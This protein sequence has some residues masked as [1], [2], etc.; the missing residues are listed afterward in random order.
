MARTVLV[1]DDSVTMQRIL[2]MTLSAL[3]DLNVLAVGDGQAALARAFELRPHL[4]IADAGMP[5]TDGYEVARTVKASAELAHIPVILLAGTFQPYDEARGASANVDAV[6]VKPFESRQ[7]IE[8]VAKALGLNVSGALP[9]AR[10]SFAGLGPAQPAVEPA[11]GPAAVFTGGFGAGFTAPVVPEFPKTGS[12]PAPGF[13]ASTTA[14][15][16]PGFGDEADS[17]DELTDDGSAGAE[18]GAA[19]APTPEAPFAPPATSQT[20][21]WTGEFVTPEP[22][23][24]TAPPTHISP[25]PTPAPVAEKPFTSPGLGATLAS[26]AAPAIAHVAATAAPEVAQL[27]QAVAERIAKETIER[28]AWEVIPQ[29]AE[30]I[31][32]EEINRLLRER[33][34]ATRG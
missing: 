32:R 15:T 30:T 27:D 16:S 33:A 3:P 25:D 31:L 19:G 2:Q 8:A 1:A 18:L 10:P 24:V 34:N 28:V 12:T 7:I 21:E 17:F 22:T 6:V 4:I 5:G 23:L 9:V 11:T 20:M 29:L 13:N 26:A 14:S